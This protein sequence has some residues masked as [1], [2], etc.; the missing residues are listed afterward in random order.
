M[1]CYF[2]QQVF[3]K[4]KDLFQHVTRDHD[5]NPRE[6]HCQ[7]CSFSA[8]TIGRYLWHMTTSHPRK[9]SHYVD[10][11]GEALSM[12]PYALD[13]ESYESPQASPKLTSSSL[14]GEA[15]GSSLVS[16]GGGRHEVHLV[17]HKYHRV[18]GQTG[19]QKSR[20]ETA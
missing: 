5:V 6:L 3:D 12:A 17:F 13:N 20:Q 8:T 16:S 1:E 9:N 19:K 10:G 7:Y 15:V 4:E 18:V 2:C 11:T 14:R